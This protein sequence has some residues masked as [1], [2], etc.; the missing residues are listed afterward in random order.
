MRPKMSSILD[1]RDLYQGYARHIVVSLQYG[2]SP[3]KMAALVPALA[4]H[5]HC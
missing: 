2:K 1:L 5:T 3:V 4:I